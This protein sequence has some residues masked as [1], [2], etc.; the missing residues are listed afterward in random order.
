M[1]KI[2]Q[3]NYLATLTKNYTKKYKKRKKYNYCIISSNKETDNL[4]LEIAL[5][6]KKAQT[7][8]I[9]IINQ[10][11]ESLLNCN[12]N[13]LRHMDIKAYQ[14]IYKSQRYDLN[15]VINRDVPLLV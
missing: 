4:L 7:K 9:R 5:K 6:L 13:R 15:I 14:G 12:G 1:V 11:A 8:L 3:Q 10:L 2:C